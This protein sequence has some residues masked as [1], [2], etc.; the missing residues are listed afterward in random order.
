MDY[1]FPSCNFTALFPQ[2]S[3][4]VKRYAESQGMVVAGCCRADHRKPSAE[5]R[6]YY[7]CTNCALILR[8]TGQAEAHAI[9]EHISRDPCFPF[10]KLEGKTF[11]IQHCAKADSA[12]KETVCSLISKMG[13]NYTES[14]EAH[15][16]GTNFMKHMTA[17]NLA[18]APHTFSALEKQVVLLD[19]AAQ[20]KALA[21]MIRKYPSGRVVTYCNSCCATLRRHGVQAIHMLELLF[22]DY[23]DGAEKTNG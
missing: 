19:E 9:L 13:G 22:S 4:R 3:A 18:I 7:A 1:Y 14:P 11:V 10:P 20:E 8:E 12:V 16:C 23:I 5:D 21:E 6:V 17:R 2:T 15:Y